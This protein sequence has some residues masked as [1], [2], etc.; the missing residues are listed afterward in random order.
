MRKACVSTTFLIVQPLLAAVCGNISGDGQCIVI[1]ARGQSRRHP[2]L[3]LALK[4]LPYDVV[5][6]ADLGR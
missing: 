1:G 3:T 5:P 2:L 6:V 4:C